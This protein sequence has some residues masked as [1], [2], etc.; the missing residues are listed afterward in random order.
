MQ[1]TEEPD[2]HAQSFKIL[3]YWGFTISVVVY[4]STRFNWG[5]FNLFHE[6]IE[7]LAEAGFIAM[8]LALTVDTYMKR[9]LSR[10]AFKAS[11]GYILPAYLQEE[12][13][14]IYSNEV[15]C[16]SHQQVVTLSPSANNLVAVR[17]RIE[18]TMKNIS[19][20]SHEFDPRV[21]MDEWL[22]DGHPSTIH[23]LGYKKNDEP[24]VTAP[25]VRNGPADD[26]APRVTVA[27]PPITLSPGDRLD[28]WYEWV[29][30][31]NRNDMH[32]LASRYSTNNPSVRVDAPDEIGWF[33]EFAHRQKSRG[34]SN[35]TN[36]PALLLPYQS[37]IV[38]W[39]DKRAEAVWR[40]ALN[41]PT[42]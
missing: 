19:T 36:L 38:R 29:E 42:S 10:D 32:M 20:V 3:L 18:R 33:V 27:L 21:D 9:A 35:T 31:R 5:P 8:V 2:A 34:Y 41:R 12:M 17:V 1:A 15:V 25:R 23:S 28:F 6:P 26:H 24:D 16:E 39:W 40:A 4:A 13:A 7:K 22:V 37:I 14:S 11:I 30:F